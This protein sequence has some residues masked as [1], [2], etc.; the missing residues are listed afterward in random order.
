MQ[1]LLNAAILHEINNNHE[2]T[3]LKIIMINIEIIIQ[4]D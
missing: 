1:I 2:K 3:F 4:K